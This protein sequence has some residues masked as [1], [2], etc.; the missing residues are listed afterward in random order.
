[1]ATNHTLLAHHFDNIEQ[2]REAELLGMWTFLATEIMIFGAIFT[3]YAAYRYW[4]PN[5]FEAASS[6]LNVLIGTINTV[7]LLSSSFTMALSVYATHAGRR[8]MLLTCLILTIILGGTFL[9]LKTFEYYT[10]YRDRL[11]PLVSFDPQEWSGRLERPVNPDHVELMLTFYYIL[12]GLH[13]THM[14]VGMG[15]LFWLLFRANRGDFNP[16]YYI[17]VEVVGLYWHFVDIVWIFLLPLLYL[18]GTHT[19]SSLHF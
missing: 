6:E 7:I 13:F 1:L 10:D 14:T 11:M 5:D 2:Q 17:P 3:G 4:Y 19:W 9:L 12:T 15:L 18:T 8:E 16:E